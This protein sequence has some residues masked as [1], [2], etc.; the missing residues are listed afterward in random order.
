[1]SNPVVMHSIVP[2]EGGKRRAYYE[3][4]GAVRQLWHALKHKNS[5]H[6]EDRFL[7][8]I[9]EVEILYKY[10]YALLY[11]RTNSNEQVTPIVLGLDKGD[12]DIFLRGLSGR[13]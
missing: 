7:K 5:H 2:T 3:K 6:F 12:L 9:T 4:D 1:M 10:K 13:C 8:Y 11:S